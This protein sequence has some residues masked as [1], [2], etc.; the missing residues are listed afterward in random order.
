MASSPSVATIEKLNDTNFATWLIQIELI[1]TEKDAWSY[2]T[3][4]ESKNDFLAT[5]EASSSAAKAAK[6]E[7]DWA[8]L[9][10]SAR[11]TIMLS[12][13]TNLLPEFAPYKDPTDLMKHIS[14]K[15]K[16]DLANSAQ[17]L[18]ARLHSSNLQQ[19]GSVKAYVNRIKQTISDI[20]TSGDIISE[21]E[22]IYVL[23][24]GLPHDWEAA[25]ATIQAHDKQDFEWSIEQLFST[26]AWKMRAAGL[27]GD[28]ALYAN[29][30]P[31]TQ[32]STRPGATG[33]ST[34]TCGNCKRFGHTK[35]QCYS[36]GGD[37][38]GKGPQNRR[39]RGI[40]K[41]NTVNAAIGST[42]SLDASMFYGGFYSDVQSPTKANQVEDH[43]PEPSLISGLGSIKNLILVDSACTHH[44]TWRR[45]LFSGYRALNPGERKIRV[46]NGELVD[47]TGIGTITLPLFA[48]GGVSPM[49][50]HD[51]LHVSGIG[52]TLLS[53]GQL[54]QSGI[55]LQHVLGKGIRLLCE[56]ALI[57][58]AALIGRLYVLLVDA[59]QEYTNAFSATIDKE[60]Y[61][62]W[63]RC[64]AHLGEASTRSIQ[65][66]V[67][68][69]TSVK[70]AP[71]D[72]SHCIIGKQIRKPYLPVSIS[73]RA[74][75]PLELIHTDLAGPF[76]VD[77]LGGARYW[78]LLID[79]YSR[80][81]TLFTLKKK[82][83]AFQTY[84][85]WVTYAEKYFEGQ[86][87]FHKVLKLR[88]DNGGEF[89]STE[90]ATY[91]K[92]QGVEHQ[93]TL[94][95][96]PQ[97][98]GVSERANRTIAGR[99]RSMM[100]DA[101][102]P[103]NFWALA[104]AAAVFV[105]NRTPTK[106]IVGNGSKRFVTPEELWTNKRAN[107][108]S[109]RVFGCVA[110][111]HIVSEKTKKLDPRSERCI[112]VGYSLTS[113]NWKF[114]NP[115]TKKL[116]LSK[117]VVFKE[118]ERFGNLGPP[119]YEAETVTFTLPNKENPQSEG[120]PDSTTISHT[121]NMIAPQQVSMDLDT[122]SEDSY[123]EVESSTRTFP[124]PMAPAP[125]LA[126]GQVRRNSF[127]SIQ[128][129]PIAIAPEQVPQLVVAP[130]R[131]RKKYPAIDPNNPTHI[132]RTAS[133]RLANAEYTEE[134]IDAYAFQVHTIEEPRT[135]KK[136]MEGPMAAAWGEAYQ[137]ELHGILDNGTWEVTELPE[138]SHEV[139]GR[140][141]NK[142]KWRINGSM[143]ERAVPICKVRYVAQGYTQQYG[144]DYDQTYAPV[145]SANNTNIIFALAASNNW[146]IISIDVCCAFLESD[147]E[148]GRTIYL[149]IPEG[150]E[151][152]PQTLEMTIGAPLGPI[153][154]AH[155]S[156]VGKRLTLRLKK[157]IYGL[158]QSPR[159]WYILLD[160]FFKEVG[161]QKSLFDGGVFILYTST[162]STALNASSAS[163]KPPEMLAV[164]HVDDIA[165]V[166]VLKQ[167]GRM[168]YV[169]DTF[170]ARFRMS[171][172]GD[173]SA[174]VGRRI[175]RDPDKCLLLID[176]KHYL[177]SVLERFQMADCTPCY[178]PME[179]KL[180]LS[181]CST[182]EEKHDI[183][184]YRSAIG[185]LIA[186]GPTRPDICYAVGVVSRFVS[187]PSKLHWQAVV[188]IFRYLKGSLDLRLVLGGSMPLELVAYGDVDYGGDTA[189][190]KSTSGY[191]AMFGTG[192]IQWK[193]TRQP[194]V[195][196]S[197][198]EAEYIAGAYA[199]TL[200]S[201]TKA[202]LEEIGFIH[203]SGKP[204]TK[205]VQ[206]AGSYKTS[207]K[208][209]ELS[210]SSKS[211]AY[212]KGPFPYTTK[213]FC[214]NEACVKSIG[215]GSI[216]P[217]PKHIGIRYF[218]IREKVANGDI[219]LHACRTGDMLA[220]GFTKP[221]DRQKHSLF[222]KAL[223]MKE[224][225]G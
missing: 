61:K 8:K 210:E 64:L 53:S 223:G 22:K 92:A 170:K 13:S 134:I 214:D 87:T 72:C 37:Q 162:S 199:C 89:T 178:T 133:K 3:G 211:S 155:Y 104:A 182:D 160:S 165:F 181:P 192:P 55:L 79:D 216:K 220:D 10:S 208:S 113:K 47:V 171:D 164:I 18:R 177:E 200:L 82:S 97:Q 108:S 80:F 57:G 33:K 105:K 98:N 4:I 88:S 175:L 56:G 121:D 60:D 6:A 75:R 136:A 215:D 65:K 90:F 74:T 123:S 115:H 17:H 131:P 225:K 68:G 35:E 190:M 2:I 106:G 83:Q 95:Y 125:P 5:A 59:G 154:K 45:E 212:Y 140:W 118:E 34:V 158:K 109:F 1:L 156:A 28:T 73:S 161:F 183:S 50:F 218:G 31:F 129:P 197:T 217:S 19:E 191:V 69:V 38:E 9:L 119:A 221:L 186:A 141:V 222:V 206:S 142:H 144:I 39:R 110:W 54:D 93:L 40:K 66:Y 185:S 146:P 51:V 12:L 111:V 85:D 148:P 139:G 159:S 81:T 147:I 48:P 99:I 84:K 152:D 179:V 26:E 70:G 126:P 169:K 130:K 52:T 49:D 101:G 172:L 112:F 188:R 138:G 58:K 189:N 201:A 20:S 30:K 184:Q 25:K 224:V 36:V 205:A 174:Y 166:D 117:H 193:S 42:P 180:K 153:K 137:K 209:P 202:L 168:K 124:T 196:Q 67:N 194:T 128:T 116:I 107:I 102:L 167:P 23:L 27:S 173:V 7:K 120:L 213:L 24:Q 78:M 16:R 187:D 76:P 195:A 96:A 32:P 145:A 219:E 163:I 114:W 14:A 204:N 143:E 103:S 135:M 149:K 207:F 63:H 44:M 127:P 150:V 71:C 21:S 11:N 77:S 151:I 62:L 43:T 157:S 41:P 86:G 46:A 132:T 29:G 176:Q 122:I 91:L 100:S 94:S 15:Y 203:L 198:T